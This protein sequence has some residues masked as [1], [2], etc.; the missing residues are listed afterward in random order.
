MK[1]ESHY[2]AL[3]AEVLLIR[4]TSRDASAL[5]AMSLLFH[6]KNRDDERKG[7]QSAIT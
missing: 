7:L 3:P 6:D 4:R 1:A 5:I 2:G